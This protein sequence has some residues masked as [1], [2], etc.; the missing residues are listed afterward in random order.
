MQ[1]S[2]ARGAQIVHAR[3][4]EALHGGLKLTGEY[5]PGEFGERADAVKHAQQYIR[6]YRHHGYDAE[7]DYWW[8]WNES[9]EDRIGLLVVPA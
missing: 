7:Q 9:A 5:V 6:Q 8:C 4:C 2:L 1:P 3:D